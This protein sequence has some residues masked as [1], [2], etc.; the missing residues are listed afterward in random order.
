MISTLSTLSNLRLRS[1]SLCRGCL[2]RFLH[3]FFKFLLEATI[4]LHSG[5]TA[6]SYRF[7][8]DIA[9]RS[10]NTS[11]PSN[12]SKL[13]QIFWPLGPSKSCTSSKSI[14]KTSFEYVTAFLFK[15]SQVTRFHRNLTN[16]GRQYKSFQG[17][18]RTLFQFIQRMNSNIQ[19][20]NQFPFKVDR[21]RTIMF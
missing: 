15:G 11:S 14:H 8:P 5:L 9:V 6:F 20:L 1:C 19:S 2:S 13:S 16:Q 7:V 21:I 17:H 12:Q 18:Q 4:S 10:R 3:L